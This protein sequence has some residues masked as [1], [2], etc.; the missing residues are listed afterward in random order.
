[1]TQDTK[2]KETLL[3]CAKWHDE[4][5]EELQR[6]SNEYDKYKDSENFIRIVAEYKEEIEMHRNFAAA[7]R[8]AAG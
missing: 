2:L 5:A 3:A 1:M 7:A 8:E 6:Q 4:R